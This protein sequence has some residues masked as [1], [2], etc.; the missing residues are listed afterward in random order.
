VPRISTVVSSEVVAPGARVHDTVEV[1]G[2]G[3]TEARIGF[4]LFGPFATRAAIRCTGR[5]YARGELYASGDGTIRTRSVQLRRVGFY[6]YRQHL[7][8]SD[9]VAEVTTE[10]GLASETVLVRPLIVTGRNDVTGARRYGAAGDALTPTRV[11]VD[12]LGIDAPVYPVGIDLRQGVL[13][14]PAQISRLGWWLD[15]MTPGTGAGS[16]LIAGHVDSATAGA[17]ALFRLREASRGDLIR[18]TTRGGRTFTYRVVSIQ[19][20][21]KAQLPPDVY[22]RRGRARLVLV[23]CG[24]PFDTA[25]GHYRDNV[26]VT[27][28]PA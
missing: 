19:T 21:P 2:L 20:V 16:V 26:V 22:S 27:A 10:C 18:V 8:G 6:T 15:G 9:L 25:T 4:E 5:P 11:R 17:G 13:D 23:T 14:A 3:A 24:G 7:P 28:V 1:S 12:D